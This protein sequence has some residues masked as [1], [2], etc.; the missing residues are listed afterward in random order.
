MKTIDYMPALQEIKSTVELHFALSDTRTLLILGV[1]IVGGFVT[2]FGMSWI[3]VRLGGLMQTL[4]ALRGKLDIQNER[5]DSDRKLF[6]RLERLIEKQN[7]ILKNLE[8]FLS[9][10]N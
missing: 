6:E 2:V 1:C 7:E 9:A 10:K 4:G 5:M 3:L 8:S